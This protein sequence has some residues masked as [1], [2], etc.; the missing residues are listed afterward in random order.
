[1]SKTILK[2]ENIFFSY[3]K[4]PFMQNI[5]FSVNEGEFISVIGENG[6]GKSTLFLILSGVLKPLSGKIFYKGKN[7]SDIS[8]REKATEIAAVY[9]N[10][11]CDFPFTC[12]EV[13]SMGL[14]PH[15]RG[16]SFY[17]LSKK[18][19]DFVYSVMEK[20]NVLK[21]ADRKITDISGGEKQRVLIARAL[22]Q[23]PKILF[24]DEATA[25]LDI[26]SKIK[27]VNLLKEFTE[28]Q[29]MTVIMISHDLQPVFDKSDKIAAMKDGR[30]VTFDIPQNL[31][32]N[33]FFSEIF[34][35][36]AEIYE[37]GRFFIS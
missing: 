3:N 30:L 33:R 34:N 20:T 2:V 10:T 12:F 29:K 37:N 18:D 25:A 31:I 7:I 32:N 21:F 17:Y 6:S 22:V 8:L 16:F 13:V 35:V 4:N 5:N 11:E 15:K 23:K 27:T 19:I 14:Y 26:S 1:M 28:K 9:Q 24:L 36:D